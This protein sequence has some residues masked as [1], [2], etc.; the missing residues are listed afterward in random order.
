MYLHYRLNTSE[1]SRAL[2]SC[3]PLGLTVNSVAYR[4]I[5]ASSLMYSP[6][7]RKVTDVSPRG[8]TGFSMFA[9]FLYCL[10]YNYKNHIDLSMIFYHCMER[11]SP[12]NS[13]WYCKYTGIPLR[14]LCTC[15]RRMALGY[16]SLRI[17]SLT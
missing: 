13:R 14:N 16:L 6:V 1:E 4:I 5:Y 9:K 7:K 8:F 12:A 17:M 2:K 15:S 11:A 3:G 10:I